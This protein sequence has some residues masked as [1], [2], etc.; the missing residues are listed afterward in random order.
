MGDILLELSRP[1]TLLNERDRQHWAKKRTEKSQ[2]AWE[3][4]CQLAW[5][6]S[7]PIHRAEVTVWRHSVRAPDQD[8]L[9]ASV[10]P[11]LDVLQPASHLHPFGLGII[12][13]DDPEHVTTRVYHIRA[14]SLR[15]QKTLVR[16]RDLGMEAQP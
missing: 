13:G 12:A 10:K 6:P 5:L 7:S 15:D 3:I 4:R 14:G 2:M 1:L 9:E 11:L 8:N 16:I